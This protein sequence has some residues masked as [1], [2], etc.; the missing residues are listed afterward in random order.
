MLEATVRLKLPPTTGWQYE[1]FLEHTR[2]N[3]DVSKA[4]MG[5]RWVLPASACLGDGRH[6]RHAL[7]CYA[8]SL[9]LP[10]RGMAAS[11]G[12][13][14]MTSRAPVSP[15]SRTAVAVP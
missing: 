1:T 4:A 12:R 9:S 13:N 2:H 15:S 14:C 7:C 3:T 6:V 8:L 10:S 11:P 5:Q